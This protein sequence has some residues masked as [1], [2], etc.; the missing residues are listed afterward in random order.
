MQRLLICGAVGLALLFGAFAS[1]TPASAHKGW[2]WH[3]HHHHHK[4][5]W[6]HHGKRH[7]RWW[8]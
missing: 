8:W 2:G 4:N 3:H 7:C 5:C 1:S 6:W